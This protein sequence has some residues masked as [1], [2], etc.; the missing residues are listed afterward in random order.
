MILQS[1]LDNDLYKFTMQHAVVKLFPR[2]E[3]RYGFVN[4]GKT[5]FPEGFADRLNQ[6]VQQMASL[7][8]TDTEK[9]FLKDWCYYLPPTYLDFLSGYQYNPK[10]VQISQQGGELSIHIEGY[11]YRTILWEV[12]LMAMIS[13]LYFEMTHQKALPQSEILENLSHKGFVF[14]KNQIRFADFGTR[15]RFSFANHDLVVGHLTKICPNAFTGTSNVFLAYKYSI[16]PIGTHAHEW[17]MFHAA[18]YGYKLANELALDN[19]VDVYR[20]DLG[21]ALSDTFTS[22]VFF[23]AF[24]GKLSKLFDGVRQDSGDPFV[25]AV[26]TIEHYKKLNIDPTSKTIVFSDNLNPDLV[27]DL[28]IFC[29]N[30]IKISFGIG[31][32]LTND[33]GVTPLNMV[34]KMTAARPANYNEWQETVKLSDSVGKYTGSAKAVALCKEM[35]GIDS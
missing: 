5:Q 12:P 19:W 16:K 23:R 31:T 28:F 10:E 13:E 17:F 2:A 22:K 24:D 6:E 34:I 8:L 15:R 3:A 21:I 18:K 25:F 26:Q 1:I 32:N 35:L 14:E 4:R 11:W 27:K 20:G 7:R 9:Q 33:V 29:E 30:R